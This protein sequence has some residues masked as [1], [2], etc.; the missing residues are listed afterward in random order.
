ML[1]ASGLMV[2]CNILHITSRA[3]AVVV[4]PDR[5][6]SF[7]TREI[8]QLC[9]PSTIHERARLQ[10]EERQMSDSPIVQSQ[11]RGAAVT[12]PVADDAGMAA[13]PPG[14]HRVAGTFLTPQLLTEFVLA[15]HADPS[16]FSKALVCRSGETFP[17]SALGEHAAHPRVAEAAKAKHAAQPKTSGAPAQ[18]TIVLVTQIDL[19]FDSFTEFLKGGSFEN[20]L[21]QQL[22][23]HG[24]GFFETRDD[25]SVEQVGDT[26]EYLT[27]LI[28]NAF[29]V[30]VLYTDLVGDQSLLDRLVSGEA[31][32][33]VLANIIIANAK[34][35]R[36]TSTTNGDKDSVE[37]IKKKLKAYTG[38][39]RAVAR[40]GIKIKALDGGE[41]KAL[42]SKDGSDSGTYIILGSKAKE[43]EDAGGA[44]LPVF[45]PD[46]T[47]SF[48]GSEGVKRV[49]NNKLDKDKNNKSIEVDKVVFDARMTTEKSARP[50]LKLPD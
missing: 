22:V 7:A 36:P 23:L 24:G 26:C 35:G 16:T 38:M 30:K 37:V 19:R 33:N 27:Y 32:L 31:D 17:V 12:P 15:D 47:G 28:P 44:G 42:K 46:P 4:A 39:L 3:T 18:E 8:A 9:P 25:A 14:Q 11:S 2:P 41:V 45:V 49:G 29:G 20:Y 43:R 21:N 50:S 1:R 6:R 10:L 13:C 34:A 5:R 48:L 40:H